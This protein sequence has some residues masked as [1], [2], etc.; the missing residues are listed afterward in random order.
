MRRGTY[1]SSQAEAI[2]GYAPEEWLADPYLWARRVHPE[3]RER[4]F[5]RELELEEPGAPEEYRMLHRNGSTVWVRD[6]AAL[7]ADEL[8]RLRWHGVLSDI[9]DRKLVEAE[10]QRRAAQQAAVAFLGRRALE[11][12]D[13]DELMNEAVREATR[14][15]GLERGAVLQIESA[16]EGAVLLRAGALSTAARERAGAWASRGSK[17]A[18]PT[19]AG[20]TQSRAD[21]SLRRHGP[22]REAAVHTRSAAR[23]LAQSARAQDLGA[24]DVVCSVIEGQEGPWGLLCVQGAQAPEQPA[25]D[26]GLPRQA[27]ANVLAFRRG[28][29]RVARPKRASATRRC[30]TR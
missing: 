1:V 13:L 25:A 16:Q 27:L 7:L 2:L 23:Q 3:D 5:A 17:R 19:Q 22:Q 10:L 20:S 29:Q 11:G 24:G 4:V 30:T 12:A 6:H 21:A 18:G 26:P 15:L 14:I 9:T 28:S 8:G